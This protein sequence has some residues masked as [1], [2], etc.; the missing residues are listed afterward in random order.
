[1]FYGV[2]KRGSRFLAAF[3][4]RADDFDHQEDDQV[5]HHVHPVGVDG[6]EHHEQRAQDG[7]NGQHIT[8]E[9]SHILALQQGDVDGDIDGVQ[10]DDGQLGGV[11]LEGAE[12]FHDAPP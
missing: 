2:R 10:G 8:L 7:Q 4:E 12:A 9:A 6:G 11:E 5:V 1:M 3:E